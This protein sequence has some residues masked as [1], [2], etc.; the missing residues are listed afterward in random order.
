MRFFLCH[1]KQAD[2]P[3]RIWD[4]PNKNFAGFQIGAQRKSYS[5][6]GIED[7]TKVC[8]AI[9]KLCSKY[10]KKPQAICW[11]GG[12]KDWRAAEPYG[13]IASIFLDS[14]F[15]SHQGERKEKNG[16]IQYK[17]DI[18]SSTPDAFQYGPTKPYALAEVHEP[19]KNY[20]EFI[21]GQNQSIAYNAFDKTD[22][23]N[24]GNKRLKFVYGPDQSRKIM[25][26]FAWENGDWALKKTKYYILGNTEIE[27][28]NVTNETR[29]LNFVYGTA[30]LEQTPTEEKLYY[31]H[32][33][34][35]GTTLA[36]T[37][38]S[39]DV[40]QRYAYDPWGRRRDP[41][42]WRNYTATE[43]EQQN[44]LF[45]RGYTGHEHLDEFG[46]INMNGRMYDPLL[47]RM[48]SPDNYVQAPG[49]S[50]NFNRYS[51]AMNNPLVY[52]DP[53]GEF[54]VPMLIGA[55][56]NVLSNGYQNSINDQPFFQG[57]GKA[58]LFG[59]ISGGVS[60]GIGQM[61]GQLTANGV[62]NF[63][64]SLIQMGSH[65]LTSGIISE[66]QGGRFS[67]GLLSGGFA[68]GFSSYA[69]AYST[70]WIDQLAAGAVGGGL[71]AE[72]AGGDFV[73]GMGQGLIT[74][75]LNH[76]IHSG[77]LGEGLMMASITGRTR[78]LFGPDAY[79]GTGSF[80]G[81]AGVNASAEVGGLYI[82]RGKYEGFH[83]Y[84][85]GGIGVGT[86][87]VSW[88]I[89]ATKLYYSGIVSEITDNTF[90]GSRVEG[91]FS[92][93][94]CFIT[95][96]VTGL[97]SILKNKEFVIGLGMGFGVGVPNGPSGNINY[98]YAGKSA[99]HIYELIHQ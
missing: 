12:L 35:Q 49:N 14:L 47:G 7:S 97:V 75:G 56:I 21:E 1:Q 55:G 11:C 60:F 17:T 9:Q 46:L 3:P 66:M 34:Y 18:S 25:K 83:P 51:Y 73:V 68:S 29:T 57:A 16:N 59:A 24:Q 19:T 40:L 70:D 71:G 61:A 41:G 90:Y 44:F 32:K 74:G 84:V 98:G 77:M 69:N 4:W 6:C 54:I 86:L 20:L 42:S 53:D 93:N 37:D 99:K 45:A 81:S 94:V 87:E 80:N 26:T 48:L 67:T 65:A 79:T 62:S 15:L 82:T 95:V 76:G 52:T 50:Q 89:E 33:D 13:R 27:V 85:D 31:L 2:T 72:I 39:G 36:V 10:K 5:F 64:V 96:G 58:A 38:E 8:G 43:I 63:G 30:I 92:V 28:D 23:I 88:T 78:H 22:Y 91:N